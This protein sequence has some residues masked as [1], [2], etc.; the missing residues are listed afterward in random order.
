MP[1]YQDAIGLKVLRIGEAEVNNVCRVLAPSISHE[2]EAGL[3]NRIVLFLLCREMHQD[4]DFRRD[5][6][7]RRLVLED[8]GGRPVEWKIDAVP[9]DQY[10]GYFADPANAWVPHREPLYRRR[11]E[12]FYWYEYL[13]ESRTLYFQFRRCREM[14]DRPFAKFNSEMFA[15][16]DKHEVKRLVLDLRHNSG[17][18]SSLLNP[19]IERL[20]GH[21]LNQEKNLYVI[22]GRRTFSSAVLNA[23]E[24]KQKTTAVFVGEPTSGSPNHYGEVEAFI[25]PN[26]HIRVEYSTKYFSTGIFGLG[27]MSWGDWLGVFGY[28]SRRFPLSNPELS[29]LQPDIRIEPE[30]SEY[31]EGRDP[32]LEYILASPISPEPSES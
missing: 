8:E 12:E 16:I 4:W 20:A 28:A 6:E 31:F 3:K 29:S 18:D 32:V 7:A 11:V 19:F 5:E 27:E 17:G 30:G 9:A 13:P 10:N 15:F 22:L 26:S 2:N 14:E 23:L 25:L 21:R 24:L 1:P